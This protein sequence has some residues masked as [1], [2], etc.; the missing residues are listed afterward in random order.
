MLAGTCTISPRLVA[1]PVYDPDAY[2]QLTA[3]SGN[4]VVQIVKVLGFFMDKMQG[5][6]VAGW[7]TT[8]PTL[9]SAGMGGD[10][11]AG[12]VVSVALVR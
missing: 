12:F 1:I 4:K 2:N 10:P 6:D 11:G 5:D 8:Y 9:P 3:T 7:I